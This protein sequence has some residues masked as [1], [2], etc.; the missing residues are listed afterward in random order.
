MCFGWLV[1]LTAFGSQSTSRSNFI[2]APHNIIY[3]Y[4]CNKLKYKREQCKAGVYLN[5]PS[6]NNEVILYRLQHAHNCHEI[7]TK[8]NS[9]MS[10]EV[11]AEIKVLF[12]FDSKIK[13][14][15]IIQI[16]TNKQMALSKKT[17]V[18]NYLSSLRKN[19]YGSHSIAS[20]RRTHFSP[21]L[22]A[23]SKNG[24]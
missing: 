6:T 1:C 4:R 15:K 16:L 11:K 13:P 14:N 20:H 23:T 19:K 2:F 18:N 10:D 8:V 21:H 5:Y 17:D 12:D 7:A 24:G 9:S 22:D 3:Y